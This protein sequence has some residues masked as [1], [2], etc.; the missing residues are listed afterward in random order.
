MIVVDSQGEEWATY[1]RA[2]AELP[3]LKAS[4]L[5]QWVARGQV[6]VRYPFAP[7]HRGAMVCL[8]DVF[9]LVRD[10]AGVAWRRGRRSAG[11][12]RA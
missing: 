12:T 7:S 2:L 11:E 6:R 5:R 9:P 3:G 1:A 4:T 8:S 10:A